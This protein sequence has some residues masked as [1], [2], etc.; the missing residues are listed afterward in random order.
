MS[1]SSER[2][3]THSTQQPS[4]EL[5]ATLGARVDQ[6]MTRH[7]RRAL[8]AMAGLIAG[9]R[10]V[11][12]AQEQ[13]RGSSS[14]AEARLKLASAAIEGVRTTISRGRFTA[15]ERDPIVIWSRR[16]YEAKVDLSKTR[17]E[18]VAAAQEHVDEMRRLEEVVDRLT[19]A[20]E[21]DRLNLMDA[22][23]RRLE[24]ENWL[25]QQKSKP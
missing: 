14:N 10:V 7:S 25:E 2:S 23:Y 6:L 20:G 17:A 3:G 15:G 5:E 11:R 12:A 9:E 1:T 19:A 21:L 8:L 18:R 24:A 13:A 4:E 22:Q 16:R